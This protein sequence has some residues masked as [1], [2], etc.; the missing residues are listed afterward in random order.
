MAFRWRAV[1]PA[2]LRNAASEQRRIVGLAN[3]D[4]GFRSFLLQHPRD[5]LERAAGAHAGDPVVQP[6]SLEVMQNFNRRG[7]GMK[8]RVGFVLELAAEEPA[9]SLRKLKCL[10]D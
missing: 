5:A 7:L 10:G 4:L 6:D 8:I 2:R 3:N 1:D 9:V